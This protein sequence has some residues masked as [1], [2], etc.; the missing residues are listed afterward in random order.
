LVVGVLGAVVF[1]IYS[2]QKARAEKAERQK[3]DEATSIAAEGSVKAKE[4]EKKK[5]ASGGGGGGYGGR[6]AEDALKN[7]VSGMDDDTLIGGECTG[8]IGNDVALGCGL[9]GFA[10]VKAVVQK[11]RAIGVTVT[12]EP[13]NP[14]V[15]A[16]MAGRVSGISWK[17]TPGASVCIK[18]FKVN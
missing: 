3:N 12:T 14:G 7:A 17:S 4:G 13:N 11:G 5:V 16:C 2:I 6:S 1:G 9:S 10:R 18:T 8:P 15:N